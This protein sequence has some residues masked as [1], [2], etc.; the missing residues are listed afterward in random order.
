MFSAQFSSAPDVVTNHDSQFSGIF[1]H[2]RYLRSLLEMQNVFPSTTFNSTRF[3]PSR[4]LTRN[5][6]SC[7]VSSPEIFSFCFVSHCKRSVG[8]R[9]LFIAAMTEESRLSTSRGPR[10]TPEAR[11]HSVSSETSNSSIED[12]YVKREGI[13]NG[14]FGGRMRRLVPKWQRQSRARK[15][16]SEWIS[17]WPRLICSFMLFMVLVIWSVHPALVW[18]LRSVPKI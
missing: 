2:S 12:G 1:F 8:V 7:S 16:P 10:A 17:S 15:S 4:I 6:L 9:R 14:R 18:I 13:Q 11:S 5:S 3:F